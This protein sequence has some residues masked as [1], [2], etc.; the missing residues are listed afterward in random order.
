M[1]IDRVPITQLPSRYGI[2]RSNLYIRLK[3]LGIEPEK[4]G[5]KGFVNAE[6]LQLLDALHDHIQKGGTTGEFLKSLD[7]DRPQIDPALVISTTGQNPLFHPPTLVA[8]VEAIVKRLLP[9]TGSRLSYLRELEEACERGWLL[10]TSEVADLLGLSPRT[11]A[12]YGQEFSDAGFVF[13]R[14][15]TRKGG[16]IAWLIDK[17]S[18]FGALPQKSVIGIKE[19]LSSEFDPE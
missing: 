10:S 7:S 18:S 3:D 14:T 11:I 1:E 12:A 19:A 2:A 5:K 16:E 8:V 6:Q 9:T 15:G 4:M 13:T 17:Q